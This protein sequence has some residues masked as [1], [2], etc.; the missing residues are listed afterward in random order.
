MLVDP[1]EASGAGVISVG[2][3]AT[4]PLGRC[5]NKIPFCMCMSENS[6][7]SFCSVPRDLKSQNYLVGR[8]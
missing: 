4:A 5:T 2:D 7:R 8:P 3:P 6:N 1:G